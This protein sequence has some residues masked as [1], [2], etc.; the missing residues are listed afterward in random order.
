MDKALF[1]SEIYV[2]S[3]VQLRFRTFLKTVTLV[4]S[5]AGLRIALPR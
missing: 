2:F 4:D 3:D 5:V 1:L